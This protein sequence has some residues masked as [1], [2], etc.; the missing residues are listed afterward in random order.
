MKRMAGSTNKLQVTIAE[1][2]FPGRPKNN[3]GLPASLGTVANVVGF[4]K[5]NIYRKQHNVP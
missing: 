4:L 2:G 5:T 1:T 3:T